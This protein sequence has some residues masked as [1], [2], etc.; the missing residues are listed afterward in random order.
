MARDG[1]KRGGFSF[2]WLQGRKGVLGE[3]GG[4]CARLL[5][6]DEAR[7]GRLLSGHVLAGGLAKLRTRLC[8]V[9]DVIN[10]LKGEADVIPKGGQGAELGGGTV[11]AHAAEAH[12]AAEQGAGLAL[13]DVAKLGEGYG[14]ALALKICNLSGDELER[15]GGAS[16]LVHQGAMRIALGGLRLSKDLEGARE[17]RITGKN[18]DPFAENLVAGRLAAPEIVVVHC[19]Q[20]VMDER[21]GVD[22]LDS[23]SCWQGI[24]QTTATGLGGG[25]EQDRAHP[26]AA[27]EERV[28]HR[29]VERG[30]LGGLPG[31]KP[32]QGTINRSGARVEIARKVKGMAIRAHF[33][34]VIVSDGPGVAQALVFSVAFPQAIPIL[35]I[36]FPGPMNSE[37]C[38]QALDKVHNPHVLINVVSRRV[39]Q[40]TGGSNRPLIT[41]TATMGLADIALTELISDKMAYELTEQ[42]PV[43]VAPQKKKRRR[44]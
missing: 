14:F 44:A 35:S 41:D 26:F 2:E 4:D 30:G 24:G 20:I 38:K 18:G 25:G 33:R 13:V 8:H 29:L 11:R 34:G 15:T 12:G 23:A 28:T 5:K 6:T 16:Q 21:V 43:A 17:K 39:R 40:L 22:A 31:Q 27:G 9:E 19:W 42:T 10:N 36:P 32:V 3:L 37:L 1:L 7:V